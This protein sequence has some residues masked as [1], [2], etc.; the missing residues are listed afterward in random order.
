MPSGLGGFTHIVFA[1]ALAVGECGGVAHKSFRNN[2][3][4]WFA[5]FDANAFSLVAALVCLPPCVLM[6]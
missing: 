1:N 2:L 4:R 6:R 3:S 5:S